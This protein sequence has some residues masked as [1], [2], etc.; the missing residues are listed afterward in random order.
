MRVGLVAFVAVLIAGPALAADHHCIALRNHTEHFVP[1]HIEG[2][3]ATPRAFR[4]DAGRVIE[5]CLPEGATPLEDGSVRLVLKTVMGMPMFKCLTR[6]NRLL[7]ITAD[8]RDDQYRLV[9]DCQ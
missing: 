5:I 6:P 2:V 1:G 9:V 8:R 4:V 7:T 3:G